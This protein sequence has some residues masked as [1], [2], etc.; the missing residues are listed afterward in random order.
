MARHDHWNGLGLDGGRLGVAGGSDG[1]EHVGMQA[2]ITEG[3][4]GR[5]L[6]AFRRGGS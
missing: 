5:L 2:E 3:D 6:G 4:G 1:L